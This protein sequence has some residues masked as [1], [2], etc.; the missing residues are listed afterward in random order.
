MTASIRHSA[1]NREFATPLWLVEKARYV[2]GGIDLDPAS[3]ERVNVDVQ[4]TRIYTTETNGLLQPG[5]YGRAFLNSPGGLLD[6][7][8]RTV[9]R[10]TKTHGGCT[11]TGA[12]GLAPGHSHEGVTSSAVVWWRALCKQWSLG[13]VTAGFFVGFSL[14]LLQSCQGGENPGHHPLDFPSCIPSERIKFDAL[15]N[16]ARVPGDQPTH[17]NV[18]VFLPPHAERGSSQQALDRLTEAFTP[19]GYLHMGNGY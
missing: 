12:C 11:E 15:V 13:N 10:K 7:Y 1:E 5:W 17:S 16:D 9:L 19:V 4:A 6:R 14:E 3:S 2:L 18:L 8:G